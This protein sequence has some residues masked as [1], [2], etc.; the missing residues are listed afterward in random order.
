LT[1]AAAPAS[2]ANSRSSE[3]VFSFAHP[4]ERTENTP[5]IRT[6]CTEHPMTATL[7]P[8]DLY[9]SD[10]H[11]NYALR[12]AVAAA[13]VV[14]V[15]ALV[16]IAASASVGALLDVDGRPAVAADVAA[17]RIVR[18]HVAQPGDTL[19]SIAER[20]RGDVGQGRFVDALIAVNGGTSIQAGQAVRLP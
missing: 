4:I 5:N 17:A 14:V 15:L 6:N 19:W 10:T 12:R 13:L 7:Y 16:A 3:Q 8:S 20:Y 11:A 18:I 9:P 1:Q 2:L